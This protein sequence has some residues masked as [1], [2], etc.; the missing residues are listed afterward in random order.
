MRPLGC[1]GAGP[2]ALLSA[3]DDVPRPRLRASAA[4]LAPRRSQR[5]PLYFRDGLLGP[6]AL[7]ARLCRP[8]LANEAQRL[9]DGLFRLGRDRKAAEFDAVR[10]DQTPC[11]DAD[12]G[13]AAP[14]GQS[15]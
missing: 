9:R 13:S 6:G 14:E 4:H 12:Y 8:P 7:G 2:S 1:G 5:G 3:L 11:L 10:R 15:D